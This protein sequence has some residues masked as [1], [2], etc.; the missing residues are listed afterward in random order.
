MFSLV[1]RLSGQFTPSTLKV[2]SLVQLAGGGVD[3]TTLRL[4]DGDIVAGT[5]TANGYLSSR[6]FVADALV[7]TRLVGWKDDVS[8]LSQVVEALEG[9]VDLTS[10]YRLQ[11]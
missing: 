7:N 6:E 4:G 10:G 1:S 9:I 11:A 8:M 3:V 2:A 5:S